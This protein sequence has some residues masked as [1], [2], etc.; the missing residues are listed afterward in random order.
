MTPSVGS[1]TTFSAEHA[2]ISIQSQMQ[3]GQAVGAVNYGTGYNVYKSQKG[4]DPRPHRLQGARARVRADTDS[5]VRADTA[6]RA[7]SYGALRAEAA[8]RADPD[9]AVHADRRRLAS[10]GWEPA[11]RR[12]LPGGH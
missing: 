11:R 3:T 6:V 12:G 5:A 2:Y 7:D 4:G 8:V 10:P 9:G 1:C